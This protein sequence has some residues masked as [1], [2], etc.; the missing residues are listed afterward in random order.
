[1]V[2]M[3]MMGGEYEAALGGDGGEVIM[4]KVAIIEALR[5]FWAVETDSGDGLKSGVGIQNS[6]SSWVVEMEEEEGEMRRQVRD[7]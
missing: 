5:V 7:E 6:A 3:V 2:M 4:V 1:M